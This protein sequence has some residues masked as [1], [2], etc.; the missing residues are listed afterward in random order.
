MR[1]YIR[2]RHDEGQKRQQGQYPTDERG[3][4][5]HDPAMSLRKLTHNRKHCQRS[6]IISITTS[7]LPDANICWWSPAERVLIA[8]TEKTP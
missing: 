2:H 4:L 6:R 7:T 3:L 1:A 5:R 8:R